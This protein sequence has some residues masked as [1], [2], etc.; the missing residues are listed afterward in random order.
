MTE[1]RQS[2]AFR[3]HW[4]TLAFAGAWLGYRALFGEMYW[5]T[6][7]LLVLV[8]IY[9]AL[10]L[11]VFGIRVAR[12]FLKAVEDERE[13]HNAHVAAAVMVDEAVRKARREHSASGTEYLQVCQ[14]RDLWKK[15]AEAAE[16]RTTVDVKID[17]PAALEPGLLDRLIRLCHPDKHNGSKTANDV[18]QQLLELRQKQRENA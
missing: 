7:V 6:W 10:I 18:T 1:Q 13:L 15:R 16:R 8:V 4:L 5:L 11:I 17:E 2:A 9:A 12:A 3:Y 14:E